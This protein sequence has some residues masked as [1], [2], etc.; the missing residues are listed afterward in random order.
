MIVCPIECD[1]CD[2]LINDFDH[3]LARVHRNLDDILQHGDRV[4]QQLHHID[5]V[6]AVDEKQLAVGRGQLEVIAACD[7]LGLKVLAHFS[8]GDFGNFCAGGNVVYPDFVDIVKH[9]VQILSDHAEAREGVLIGKL[10]HRNGL[11]Q[12][13]PINLGY[14]VEVRDLV[15]D[16]GGGSDVQNRINCIGAADVAK[17]KLVDGSIYAQDIFVLSAR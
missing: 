2:I 16:N 5:R 7:R 6:D 4:V 9:N 17:L 15:D 13:C 14:A 10:V 3:I 1:D 8:S 12:K 11:A